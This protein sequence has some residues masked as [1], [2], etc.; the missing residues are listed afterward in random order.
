MFEL[1]NLDTDELRDVCPK[2]GRPMATIVDL[3]QYNTDGLCV[4]YAYRAAVAMLRGR[5]AVEN[6]QAH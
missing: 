5:K 1:A 3:S 2:C 4:V 6:E